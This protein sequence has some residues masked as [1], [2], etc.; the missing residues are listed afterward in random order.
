MKIVQWVPHADAPLPN[1]FHVHGLQ[2]PTTN[3]PL[4]I[5]YYARTVLDSDFHLLPETSS[6][7]SPLAVLSY[8][9][10]LL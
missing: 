4:W 8:L 6:R 3:E 9:L 1:I 7:T 2:F 5:C 10:G